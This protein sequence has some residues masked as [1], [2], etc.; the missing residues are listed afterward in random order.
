M[1]AAELDEGPDYLEWWVIWYYEIYKEVA[2][3]GNINCEGGG[4][5]STGDLVEEA[6]VEMEASAQIKVFCRK[7]WVEG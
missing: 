4:K 5:F 7:N 3:G 1:V 2:V 6:E